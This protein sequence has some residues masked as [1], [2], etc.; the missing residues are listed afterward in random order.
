[1]VLISAICSCALIAT[2]AVLAASLRLPSLVSYILAAYVAACAAVVLLTE[3]LSAFRL[4]TPIGYLA[5]EAVLFAGSLVVWHVRGRPT[6]PRPDLDLRA[7]FR[8]PVV[9]ALAAVVALAFAYEAFLVIATPPNNGDSLSGHLSRVAA[10]YQHDGIFW[11]PDAHTP[12]QNEWPPVAQIEVLYTV[13]LLGGRDTLAAL[14]QLVAGL[15]LALAVF[16]I[17]RRLGFARAAAAFSA[18]I[19][20]TLPQL[21]LQSVTTQNDLIV[22]SFVAVA[23]YFLHTRAPPEAALAGLACA[24]ALGTKV[25]AFLALPI[26][27][28]LALVLLPRR[29]LAVAAASAVASFAAVGAYGYVRNAAHTGAI[30]GSGTAQSGYR[31]TAITFRGTVSSLAKLT[32]HMLDFSGYHAKPG[33]REPLASAGE[34]VFDALNIPTYPLE[35]SAYPFTFDP[36]ITSEEDTSWYGPLG[37]LLIVPVGLVIALRWRP[38]RAHPSLLVHALA[39]PA[40]ALALVLV[41]KEGSWYGRYLLLAIALALPLVAAVYRIRVLAAGSALLGALTL[42]LVHAYNANKPT[43]LEKTAIWDVGR[44]QA[45]TISLPG[46]ERVIEAVE[47]RSGPDE[48]VGVVMG[49]QDWDYPFYGPR[50]ERPLVALP[51]RNVLAEAERRRLRIVVLGRNLKPPPASPGWRVVRFSWQGT[52]LVDTAEP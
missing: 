29:A 24:L 27:V 42:A 45:Q 39:V 46:F 15:A 52:V 22:A 20:L 50:L 49:E 2:A 8:H 38:R 40:Y 34:T 17:A 19:A 35:S 4:A 28:V 3:V 18:L 21:A 41:Y 11:I 25:T 47:A 14:P 23:A 32:W 30:F 6:P 48:P 1:M 9:V 5:A 33:V 43:G 13:V 51:L 31:P 36:N 26:L 12:R 44:T 16:G 37:F 7:L 10:W